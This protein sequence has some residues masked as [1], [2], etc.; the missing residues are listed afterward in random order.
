MMMTLTQDRVWSVAFSPDGK[1]V[2]AGF[3]NQTVRIW[4]VKSHELVTTLKEDISTLIFSPDN[5][6]II[7]GLGSGEIKIVELKTGNCIATLK[8]HKRNVEGLVFSPSGRT[9]ASASR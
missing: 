8:G 3:E 1:L 5:K 4:D 7:L 2:A 6:M 9:L